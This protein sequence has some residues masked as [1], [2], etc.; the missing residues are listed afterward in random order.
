MYEEEHEMTRTEKRE[1]KETGYAGDHAPK[2]QWQTT[3]I[4]QANYI[5]LR[6]QELGIRVHLVGS[7]VM[8]FSKKK[9]PDLLRVIE[10]STR[11]LYLP[12]PA[13]CSENLVCKHERTI[14]GVMIKN[15][16]ICYTTE[17]HF[18]ELKFHIFKK[19]IPAPRVYYV[20][21]SY[22]EMKEAL[23]EKERLAI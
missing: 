7:T 5:A 1:L 21:Q 6:A 10:E 4:G 3:H 18:R 17:K 19:D 14:L 2:F 22:R 20:F 16:S 23:E 15:G 13:L 9:I 12:E 8:L 11:Y